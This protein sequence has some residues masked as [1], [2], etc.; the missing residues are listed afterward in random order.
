MIR[1]MNGYLK[2]MD[3]WLIS[4]LEKAADESYTMA[5]EV[6]LFCLERAEKLGTSFEDQAIGL[7]RAMLGPIADTMK[8]N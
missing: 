6:A 3:Q 1:K 4:A 2:R 7:Y 8:M 5:E